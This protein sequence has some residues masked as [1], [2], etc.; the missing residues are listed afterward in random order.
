[1]TVKAQSTRRCHKV[2]VRHSYS[3]NPSSTHRRQVL[4]DEVGRHNSTRANPL[5]QDPVI[6]RSNSLLAVGAPRKQANQ[7]KRTAMAG[8][9]SR[10]TNKCADSSNPSSTHR[11]QVLHDNIG[12]AVMFS[13]L[14]SIQNFQQNSLHFSPKMSEFRPY[15]GLHRSA[16]QTFSGRLAPDSVRLSRAF[17]DFPDRKGSRS[18][19]R[20]H[21]S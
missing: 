11:R 17:I 21:R 12:I 20:L 9:H 14:F 2:F 16:N 6:V 5:P 8:A 19:T 13:Q 18:E 4:H 15:S 10:F 1:L 3:S 7:K